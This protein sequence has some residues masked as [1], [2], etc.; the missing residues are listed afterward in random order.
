MLLGSCIFRLFVELIS[1]TPMLENK[2]SVK[3]ICV[4]LM[5][6][7][8]IPFLTIPLLTIPHYEDGCDTSTCYTGLL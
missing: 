1:Q 7:V 5:C 6:F 4:R 2:D 8:T 3:N